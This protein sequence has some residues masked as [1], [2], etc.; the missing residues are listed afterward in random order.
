[1]SDK[2]DLFLNGQKL[3]DVQREGQSLTCNPPV[4]AI[5]RGR[6]QLG[7][8]MTARADDAAQAP[9][10]TNVQLWVRYKS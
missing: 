9:Q 5:K 8:T 7:V 3:Q 4:A 10:V 2:V 1:M 6:N